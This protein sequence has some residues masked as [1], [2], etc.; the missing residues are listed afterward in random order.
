M[1]LC[2]AVDSSFRG[3]MAT[4][5]FTFSERVCEASVAMDSSL[6]VGSTT[7]ACFINE[8]ALEQ[9]TDLLCVWYATS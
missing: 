1:H 8:L 5:D 6:R 3:V 9:E 2:M 4:S 7:L